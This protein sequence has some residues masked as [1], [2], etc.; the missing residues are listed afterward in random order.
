MKLLMKDTTHIGHSS[1]ITIMSWIHVSLARIVSVKGTK[2]QSL[3]VSDCSRY[4]SHDSAAI[5][6]FQNCPTGDL[7]V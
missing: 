7:V 5:E 2:E 6:L 1:H 3:N 4:C